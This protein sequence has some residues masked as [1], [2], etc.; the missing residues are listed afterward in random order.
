[1]RIA[2]IRPA[3]QEHAEVLASGTTQTLWGNDQ[4]MVIGYSPSFFEAHVQSW[5]VQIQ[6]AETTRQAIQPL[7]AP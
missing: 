3:S 6:K 2:G 4:K 7:L 1:M 5:L